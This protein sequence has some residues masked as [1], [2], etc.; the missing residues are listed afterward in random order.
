MAQIPS[1]S[2]HENSYNAL[3]G[4]PDMARA[5]CD[6]HNSSPGSAPATLVILL[7][8]DVWTSPP[9]PWGPWYMLFPD[10]TY[11]SFAYLYRF[12]TCFRSLLTNML[13]RAFSDNLLKVSISSQ[14]THPA[15]FIIF[16]IQHIVTSNKNSLSLFNSSTFPYRMY[17]LNTQRLL[18]MV[19]CPESGTESAP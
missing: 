2:H 12:L 4:P 8:L 7:S 3:E 9:L 13:K 10:L 19:G 1:P 11:S 6:L 18:L 14:C 15:L 17:T 5:I 16:R